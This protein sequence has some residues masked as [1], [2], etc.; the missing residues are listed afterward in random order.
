MHFSIHHR[1]F[2]YLGNIT[3]R[4]YLMP[5]PTAIGNASEDY[6]FG[7]LYARKHKRKLTVIIP[8]PMLKKTGLTMFDPAF[9]AY[10]NDL[11]APKYGSKES[12]IIN[13]VVGI[14]FLILRSTVKVN[15]KIFKVSLPDSYYHPSLGQDIIWRPDGKQAFSWQNVYELNWINQLSNMNLELQLPTELEKI[16]RNSFLDMGL[17]ADVWY[18]CFHVREGGYSGDFDNIRNSD[19]DNYLEAMEYITS[20]GGWVIRMGDSS[21]KKLPPLNHVIDYAHSPSRS[22]LMDAYLIRGCKFFVGTSSGIMDTALLF[23]KPSL[24]T[25]SVSYINLLPQKSTDLVIFK[26]VFS[27]SKARVISLREWLSSFSEIASSTWSSPDWSFIENSSAEI[28]QAVR[29]LLDPTETDSYLELQVDF[30]RRHLESLRS[31]RLCFRFSEREQINDNEW[32]RF[33]SRFTTWQGS[34]AS[35]YLLKNW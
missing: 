27:K 14:Y 18:V 29:E 22:A 16:C 19:I 10:G 12:K 13:F 17:P 21:M 15:Y 6:L 9:L 35:D 34:V 11:T 2:A 23:N 33:A 1:L 7:L 8:H 30:K 24:L 26:H 5:H 3:K 28:T 4:V 20:K 25:N 32:Y 31:L